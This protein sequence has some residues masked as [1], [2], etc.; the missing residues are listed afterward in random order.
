MTSQEVAY[1]W[2]KIDSYENKVLDILEIF[3]DGQ[4]AFKLLLNDS[5]LNAEKRK[6]TNQHLEEIEKLMEKTPFLD[7]DLYTLSFWIKELNDCAYWRDKITIDGKKIKQTEL[8]KWCHKAYNEL[9]FHLLS[10]G[11]IDLNIG[12]SGIQPKEEEDE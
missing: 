5:N 7:F 11:L 3:E 6:L 4:L 9:R 2:Q 1:L 10:T 8:K 12:E